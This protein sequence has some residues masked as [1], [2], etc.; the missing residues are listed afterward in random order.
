MNH[1]W[2]PRCRIRQCTDVGNDQLE[3]GWNHNVEQSEQD[4]IFRHSNE[5][6]ISRVA[7][8]NSLISPKSVNRTDLG[9]TDLNL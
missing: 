5:T 1:L 4:F 7:P 9:A 8:M 2:T 3:I 6:D